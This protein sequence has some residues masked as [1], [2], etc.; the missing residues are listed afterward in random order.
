MVSNRR[1]KEH[2]ELLKYK[3]KLAMDYRANLKAIA[4]QP[5]IVKKLP[6]EAQDMLREVAQ[7]LA[8]AS[9]QNALTLRA[10]VAATQQL[11]Q[12]VVAM[13]KTEIAATKSYKNP[14]KAHLMLGNYSPTCRPV[15]ISR[16]V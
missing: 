6:G 4:A 5:D 13:V 1:L 14:A 8:K 10:A 16:S 2:P 7:K 12:N 15:A 9:E 11:I 3:Q